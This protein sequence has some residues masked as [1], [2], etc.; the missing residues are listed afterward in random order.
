VEAGRVKVTVDQDLCA[1]HARCAEICPSVFAS[2]EEGYAVLPGGG[3]V[4]AGEED[5]ADVAIASCPEGAIA[6]VAA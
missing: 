4:P 6:E 5:A 1:G 3:V 2:D